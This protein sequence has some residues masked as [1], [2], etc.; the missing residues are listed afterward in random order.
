MRI[1]KITPVKIIRVETDEDGFNRY[2][3]NAP[4]KW[5]CEMGDSNEAVYEYEELEDLYQE[6]KN[7]SL[8]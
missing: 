1:I 5:Y 8:P 3:R 6:Y 7:T 2:L 4:D